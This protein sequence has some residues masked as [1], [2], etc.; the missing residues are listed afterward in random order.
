[1][2]QEGC[3]YFRFH[4]APGF[5]VEYHSGDTHELVV[6]TPIEMAACTKR[7]PDIARNLSE[8]RT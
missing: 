2:D 4:L 5:T 6:R 1:M 3:A 8:Y 7:L